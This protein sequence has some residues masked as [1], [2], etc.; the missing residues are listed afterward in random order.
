MSFRSALLVA[1]I[2]LAGLN[3]RPA[4]AGVS[5]LLDE[6]MTDVGLS[7]A[8]AD[9]ISTVMVICLGVFG[10]LAPLL[11]RRIGLDRTLLA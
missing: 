4:I 11:A 5:P 2:V 3:L 7:P 9:G 6:I 1:G 10:P 8:G